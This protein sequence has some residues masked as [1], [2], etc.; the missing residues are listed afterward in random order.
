MDMLKALILA[1]AF[2]LPMIAHAELEGEKQVEYT[3]AIGKGNLKVVQKYLDQGVGVNDTYFAWSAIQIA[4]NHGQIKMAQ[5]LLDKGADINYKHPITKMTAL[6]MA[7]YKNDK[8][9]VKFLV[10]K[11]ADPNAKLR[12][13]VSI[14]R[15]VRDENLNEMAELLVSLGASEEGCEGKCN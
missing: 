2:S 15:A 4:A 9:M 13:G 8:E 11:G 10:A 6:H 7:A 5:L 1:V 12:G 3:D 14:V